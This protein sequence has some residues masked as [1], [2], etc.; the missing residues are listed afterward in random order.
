M[1]NS[2]KNNNF[3]SFKKLL[4][5]IILKNI[6]LTHPPYDA[7]IELYLY[8][9]CYIFL[10]VYAMLDSYKSFKIHTGEIKY[11]Y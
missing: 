10:F 2:Y 5:I 9:N 7:S 3:H 11:R 8:E 1:L 6:N 4:S